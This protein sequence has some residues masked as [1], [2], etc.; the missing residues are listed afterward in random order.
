[1][2]R[3]E[4]KK[5]YYYEIFT[6]IRGMPSNDKVVKYLGNRKIQFLDNKE[7][8]ELDE[9][10]TTHADKQL[11]DGKNI[12][13]IKGLFG[14]RNISIDPKH[15][16]KLGFIKKEGN[17]YEMDNPNIKIMMNLA[18]L[19]DEN[20]NYIGNIVMNNNEHNILMQKIEEKKEEL[21]K[22][23]HDDFEIT[24]KSPFKI[25][26]DYYD[27]SMWKHIEQHNEIVTIIN[28][29]FKGIR[30]INELFKRLEKEGIKIEN[31]DEVVM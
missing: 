31:K 25:I 27:F 23:Y 19:G 10:L 26:N 22:K 1:M 6:K 14:F 2:E 24:N 11:K 4:L 17:L 20:F 21:N 9:T 7:I 5:E 30:N 3:E 15:L 29:N 12:T 16:E 28:E 18:I 13:Y 8:L